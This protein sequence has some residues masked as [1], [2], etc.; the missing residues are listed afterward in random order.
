MG[1]QPRRAC[2]SKRR[3]NP[4]CRGASPQ[5]RLRLNHKKEILGA[6]RRAVRPNGEALMR[7]LRLSFSTGL[8]FA[9]LALILSAPANAQ[10][11]PLKGQVSSADESAME[12][13]L[14]SAKRD[15]ASVTVTVVTDKQGRY[16]F[17][18]GRLGPGHYS[19]R[20]RAVG[21]D[22]DSSA[23]AAVVANA[24]A[25]VDLKLRKNEDLASQ[26]SN[27][28]WIASVPGTDQ[29]KGGLLNCLGCHTLERIVKSRHSADDFMQ[30]L[31]RMQGYVNQSIPAHPQLRRA[32]RLMEE[33]GDQRVQVHR[34][35]AEYLATINLSKGPQWDYALKTLPRPTG[36]ATR[37]V[38]TEYDL[39]RETIEPH[40]VI[41]DKDGIAW[42]SSFGEPFLGRLDPK[43]SKVT[44]FPL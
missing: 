12:G 1:R 25:T 6:I 14:V 26:L 21:Y 30:V 28:E 39:G 37:V 8:I 33:R 5:Y 2:R 15:G 7:S 23:T 18:A 24:S 3:S 34:N 43:T 44:E 4:A 42:Y 13:V 27:G 36:R 38:I 41:V 16:S 19:L 9:S 40:D 11:A 32:E 20:V 35:L 22:L 29:Q 17:P 31:P 10:V